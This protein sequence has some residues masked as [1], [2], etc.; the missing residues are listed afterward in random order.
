LHAVS[1]VVVAAAAV[2][3]SPWQLVAGLAGHG[4]KVVWQDRTDV[5]ADTKWWPGVP[6]A[7]IVAE[8]AAGIH[9]G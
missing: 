3:G 6:A 2:S 5:V 4:L 1:G 8:I 9:F 7:I